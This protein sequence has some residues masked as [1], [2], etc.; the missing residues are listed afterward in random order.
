[1]KYETSNSQVN[2]S[3]AE[4]LD[5][6]ALEQVLNRGS[7]TGDQLIG[8]KMELA[9]LVEKLDGPMPGVPEQGETPRQSGLIGFANDQQDR[10]DALVSD[11]T[12]LVSRLSGLI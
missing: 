1:M 3:A 2:A 10:I 8:L 11:C 6:T 12:G 7:R 5:A 9:R 4:R